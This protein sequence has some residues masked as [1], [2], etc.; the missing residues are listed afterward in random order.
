MTKLTLLAALGLLVMTPAVA[1]AEEMMAAP[2]EHEVTA[3]EGEGVV[4][5]AEEATTT[6]EAAP[7]V[8]GEA[9]VA[10]PDA[11]AEAEAPATEEVTS[12][13]K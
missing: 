11:A 4:A 1:H 3:T 7:A 9:E 10:A 5:P 8:E 13:D 2:V 6:E 12:E